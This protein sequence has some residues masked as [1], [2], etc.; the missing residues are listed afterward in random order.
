MSEQ[1]DRLRRARIAAGFKTA[2]AAA[3]RFNFRANTYKSNENGH[4]PFSYAAAREYALAYAVSAEWLYDG[5][6]SDSPPP[7]PTG[8]GA[9]VRPA[10]VGDPIDLAALRDVIRAMERPKSVRPRT[11][12]RRIP[13]MGEVAAGLWREAS[14][15][16]I[17]DAKEFLPLDVLGYEKARLTALRVVGPSMNLVYPEGRYVVVA[18]PAEAGLRIG[19]IVVV[20]RFKS[21]LV[22]LTLK[23]FVVDEA[24]RQALMPRSTHPDFQTPIYLRDREAAQQTGLQIVGVV[25]ADYSKRDRPPLI[26]STES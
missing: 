20:E 15:R 21:D 10:P 16:E 2:A 22:E 8:G 7:G 19:D 17:A 3:R 5:K 12:D 14:P 4:A 25:V 18:H 6:P 23:E 13:V 9:V 24:G 26:F 1:G 11:I